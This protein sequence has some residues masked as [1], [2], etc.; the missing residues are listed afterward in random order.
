MEPGV[1]QCQHAKVNTHT[2]YILIC[3]ILKLQYTVNFDSDQ[4]LL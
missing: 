2:M 3:I 4:T 1:E